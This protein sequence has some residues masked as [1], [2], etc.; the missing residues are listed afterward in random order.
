[1]TVEEKRTAG[2]LEVG[3]GVEAGAGE[4]ELGAGPGGVAGARNEKRVLYRLSDTG[5][6]ATVTVRAIRYSV[7]D[8]EK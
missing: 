6:S 5:V 8:L 2:K 1:M 4:S 7:L 3:A